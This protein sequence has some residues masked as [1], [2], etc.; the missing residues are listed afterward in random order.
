MI[1]KFVKFADTAF[2]QIKELGDF[3]LKGANSRRE[4]KNTAI[5]TPKIVLYKFGYFISN[6]VSG[7]NKPSW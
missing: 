2:T 3:L 7:L 4:E 1:R 5:L 6:S